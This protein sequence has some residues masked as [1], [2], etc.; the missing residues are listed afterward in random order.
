[1]NT[2]TNSIEECLDKI[3]EYSAKFRVDVDI[4]Q[5]LASILKLDTFIDNDA[6][7]HAIDP[8]FKASYRNKVKYKRLS[9]AG[10]SILIDIDFIDKTILGVWI[11]LAQHSENEQDQK[12]EQ[13]LGNIEQEAD[14][15]IKLTVDLKAKNSF[16]RKPRGDG[17]AAAEQILLSNFEKGTL[18]LFSTNLKYLG[19]LDKYSASGVDMFEYMDSIASVL[20][21]FQLAEEKHNEGWLIKEGLSSSFGKIKINDEKDGLLGIYSEFWRDDRYINHEVEGNNLSI[22]T[23][24][25]YLIRFG[26][27]SSDEKPKDYLRQVREHV[28]K[29]LDATS[30]TKDCIV[31]YTNNLSGIQF[32]E[33]TKLML[34]VEFLHSFFIPVLVLEYLGLARYKLSLSEIESTQLFD[35][36]NNNQRVEY[37]TK[38]FGTE[39]KLSL[40]QKLIQEYVPLKFVSLDD[41]TVLP[42][43]ISAARNYLVLS[44]LL[45][46]ISNK[47]FRNSLDEAEGASLSMVDD[48]SLALRRKLKKSLSLSKDVTDEELQALNADQNNTFSVEK[49]STRLDDFLKKENNDINSDEESDINPN[50]N[51]DPYISLS[52]EDIDFASSNTDIIISL[53]GYLDNSNHDKGNS[54]SLKF[55]ISNGEILPVVEIDELAMMIDNKEHDPNVSVIKKISVTEDIIS[56]LKYVYS[57]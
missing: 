17:Q 2:F 53:E 26:V 47:S 34:R 9:I 55:R 37:L 32:N 22:S 31:D 54:F 45:R 18:S 6:Y 10:S 52:I 12:V 13:N 21:A 35:A 57:S 38:N 5:K 15:K 46:K 51:L 4:I 19:T 7:S 42:K 24:G 36:L 16:I 25:A 49:E 28:W 56:A 14:G 44:N 29:I 1:M 41:I 23:G 27:D 43:L 30:G 20:S 39:T 33:L 3:F 48:P 11:S 40:Q 8:E 50:Q